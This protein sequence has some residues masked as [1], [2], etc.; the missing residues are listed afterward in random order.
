[1]TRWRDPDA[2]KLVELEPARYV[3]ETDMAYLL[4][5]DDE[6]VWIPKSQIDDLDET[7]NSGGDRIFQIIIP[8]WLALEKGLDAFIRD[9]VIG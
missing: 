8:Q 9:T 1:M 5:F 4:Q 6:K 2:D 7:T 3:H